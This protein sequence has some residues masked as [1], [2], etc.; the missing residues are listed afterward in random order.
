MEY[1]D[2][3][4]KLIKDSS[5]YYTSKLRPSGHDISESFDN[6]NDGWLLS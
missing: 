1:S 5:K 3:M 2:R 6:D 4:K